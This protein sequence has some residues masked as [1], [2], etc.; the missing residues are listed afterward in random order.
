MDSLLLLLPALS[1]AALMFIC[2]RTMRHADMTAAS[3]ER[4]D[5][6]RTELDSLR[7]EV[8]TLRAQLDR[9]RTP[10]DG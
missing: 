6:L 9:E 5:P 3:E 10:V 2:F 7:Q 8:A 1:C 4:E